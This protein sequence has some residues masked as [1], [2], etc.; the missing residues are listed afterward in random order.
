MV[1]PSTRLKNRE[2]VKISGAGFTANDHVYIVECLAGATSAA[3]CDLKTLKAVTIRATGVLPTTNFKV[4]AGKIGTGACGTTK[5]NLCHQ[6]RQRV[7]ARLEGGSN[8]LCDAEEDLKYPADWLARR[9]CL[10]TPSPSSRCV[11]LPTQPLTRR[12]RSHI[13]RSII[14]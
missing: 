3:R 8:H 5:S 1:H 11:L 2:L 7:Q 10:P 9:G 6:C 14:P 12:P 4:I 13:I